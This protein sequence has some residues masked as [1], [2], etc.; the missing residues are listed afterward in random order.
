MMI[1]LVNIKTFDE[2]ELQSFFWWFLNITTMIWKIKRLTI[3]N[4]PSLGIGHDL[5][6]VKCGYLGDRDLLQGLSA[7]MTIC[8]CLKKIK[9]NCEKKV[10]YWFT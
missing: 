4:I 1:V 9:E 10:Y 7:E 5:S 6:T 2:N 8:A 3:P